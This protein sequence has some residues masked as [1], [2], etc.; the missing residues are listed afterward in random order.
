M[1]HGMICR[2]GKEIGLLRDGAGKCDMA[3][4]ELSRK[5]VVYSLR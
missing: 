3:L 1:H 4:E 5:V 2:Q